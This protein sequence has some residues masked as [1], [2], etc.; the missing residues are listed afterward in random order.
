MIMKGIF[1]FG[2][3]KEESNA[4]SKQEPESFLSPQPSSSVSSVT[5][6]KKWLIQYDKKKCIGSG[7]CEAVA[8]KYWKV[9]DDGK[10]ELIGSVFNQ[11][12]QMFERVIGNDEFDANK[13]AADGCPPNCIHIINKETGEKII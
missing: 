5:G 11:E 6:G 12:T 1:G 13:S 8:E 3:K 4:E 7:T 10:A 2:K 9:R